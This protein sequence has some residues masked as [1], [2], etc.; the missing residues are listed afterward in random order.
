VRGFFIGALRVPCC[1]QAGNT[2][3]SRVQGILVNGMGRPHQGSR[4]AADWRA[5]ARDSAVIQRAF[6]RS[7][8]AA[9]QPSDT[10]RVDMVNA[11]QGYAQVY[12]TL[13]IS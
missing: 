2:V 3:P 10:S 7:V 5:L 12:S 11:I 1:G 13:H 6:A 8:T 4:H 9:Q